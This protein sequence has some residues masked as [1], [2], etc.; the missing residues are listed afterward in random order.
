MAL[1]WSLVVSIIVPRYLGQTQ[2]GFDRRNPSGHGLVP[3]R[4][5]GLPGQ[6]HGD[7]PHHQQSSRPHPRTPEGTGQEPLR[8]HGNNR[9]SVA[10][11]FHPDPATSHFQANAAAR[12]E[13]KPYQTFTLS[14]ND[15]DIGIALSDHQLNEPLVASTTGADRPSPGN[16]L[17]AVNGESVVNPKHRL[18]P[19]IFALYKIN[20][21]GRPISLTFG[22]VE[23][24]SSDSN[25]DTNKVEGVTSSKPMS[26]LTFEE[27]RKSPSVTEVPLSNRELCRGLTMEAVSRAALG[28]NGEKKRYFEVLRNTTGTKLTI[29]PLVEGGTRLSYNSNAGRIL[30]IGDSITR[31]LFEAFHILTGAP[32]NAVEYIQIMGSF[33]GGMKGSLSAYRKIISE[34]TGLGSTASKSAPVSAVFV[35]GLG[36]WHLYRDVPCTQNNTISGHRE[37]IE[38]HLAQ[39]HIF[40]IQLGI[41]FV[42]IGTMP[43][44]ILTMSMSPKHKKINDFI[45]LGHTWLWDS[46]ETSSFQSGN[47]GPGVLHFRPYWVAQHCPGVRCDGM[48]FGSDYASYNCHHS[49]ALWDRPLTQFLM[50]KLS[51]KASPRR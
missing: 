32:K 2:T 27:H 43:L 1:F 19:F 6:Q 29:K 24:I 42:F 4:W 40:S 31:E 34:S 48:H 17:L 41:P 25:M 47:F 20:S 5:A 51:G 3:E 16:I 13:P 30:F 21:A 23:D 12:S 49:Q 22:V 45:D 7:G 10:P 9:D 11:L 8:R 38:A 35:G 46:V 18:S 37:L 26:F 39:L 50:N 28:S 14:Y 33:P 44:D 15:S 36:L